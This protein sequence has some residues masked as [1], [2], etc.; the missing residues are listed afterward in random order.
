MKIKDCK[1]IVSDDSRLIVN[2][3]ALS[4]K[5]M[6]VKAENIFYAY[7]PSEVANILKVEE[8]NVIIMDYNF[9]SYING[10]QLYY[11]LKYSELINNTIIFIYVTGENTSKI[12]RTIVDSNPDDYILKPFTHPVVK[13]RLNSAIKRKTALMPIYNFMDKNDLDAVIDECNNLE[14]FY[15][16]YSNV[17][18]KIKAETLTK[19]KKYEQAKIEYKSMLNVSKLDWIKTS[20]ANVLMLNGDYEEA[21]VTLE[22]VRN[23]KDNHLYHDEMSNVKLEE[24]D[25]PSA[26]SHLKTSTMLLESSLDRDLI[27]ANLSVAYGSYDDGFKYIKRYYEQNI[28]TYRISDEVKLIYVYYF[29]FKCYNS[30][31]MNNITNALET[32]KHLINKFSASKKYSI[33]YDLIMI[34]VSLLKGEFNQSYKFLKKISSIKNSLNLSYYDY[35]F[36]SFTFDKFS[37]FKKLKTPIEMGRSAINKVSNPNIMRSLSY[38]QDR[39]EES[40]AARSMAIDEKRNKFKSLNK[41]SD[42]YTIILDTLSELKD[43]QPFSVNTLMYIVKFIS[44]NPVNYTGNIDLKGVLQYCHNIISSMSE[45]DYLYKI[46][47]KNTYY[48]AKKKIDETM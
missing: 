42:N 36:A 43:L 21:K 5:Q 45:A 33:Q 47:Y 41:K 48:N 15:P 6:G 25:I 13:R 2:S 22:N 4:L 19:L 40:I 34:N 18:K 8:I 7:K 17:I 9:N 30:N 1:V 37:D 44:N 20:L 31:T 23:K 14:P 16:E 28:N 35:Y 3:L 46:N 39:L 12:V 29:I 38:M 24:K 11:E 26:I 27:I 32:I 10:H